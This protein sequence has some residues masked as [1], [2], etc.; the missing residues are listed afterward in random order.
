MGI[1]HNK[2]VYNKYCVHITITKIDIIDKNWHRYTKLHKRVRYVR[3]GRG[4]KVLT[5]LEVLC[6]NLSECE[7]LV[8]EVGL[9][10]VGLL[11]LL[12]CSLEY[13]SEKGSE[14]LERRGM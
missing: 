10:G 4:G 9:T 3:G 6:E 8:D 7:G 13:T 5:S 2:N 1:G 11:L 12:R 14:G